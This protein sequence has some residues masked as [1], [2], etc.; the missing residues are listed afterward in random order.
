MFQFKNGSDSPLGEPDWFYKKALLDS[1]LGGLF[2]S[3]RRIFAANTSLLFVTLI[4]KLPVISRRTAVII[5]LL[6]HFF[7]IIGLSWPLT[8]PWFQLLV[9]VDL[10][11]TGSLLFYF[12]THFSRTF[13]SFAV[14]LW[15]AT[16][17]LE[18]AGVHTQAIFG[19]YYYGSAFG[20][21]IFDVPVLIG[22]NWLVIIY[23][24]SCIVAPL[25][26]PVWLRAI[27]AAV[28]TT[29]LDLFIEPV[30]IRQNFW[31]WKNAHIPTQNFVAWFIT[32]F[33]LCFICL[34]LPFKKENPLAVP[35]Y[36]IQLLFFVV[37]CLT[38]I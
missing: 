8:R 38:S 14:A 31:F 3:R 35:V 23:A 34:W 26:L 37:L 22:L 16:W 24:T 5:L 20:F 12:H 7:G 30:A 9:P 33:V 27:L 19:S 25:A 18:V 13:I 6:F 32:S 4:S 11:I 15:V 29:G 36:V 21:Q 2:Q 17:A 28:L 1:L 10:L